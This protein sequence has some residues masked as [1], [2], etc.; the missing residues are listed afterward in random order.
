MS[1]NRVILLNPGN[2]YLQLIPNSYTSKQKN[3]MELVHYSL[4]HVSHVIH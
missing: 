3:T 1:E 4:I 2:R